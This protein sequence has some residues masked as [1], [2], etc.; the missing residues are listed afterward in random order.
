[1]EALLIQRK[2]EYEVAENLFKKGFRSEIKL[3][4]SRTNFE[5]ALALYEKSQV[6]LNNTKVLIPFDSIIDDSFVLLLIL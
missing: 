3:S 5:N 6:D 2:K 4:K 1:M